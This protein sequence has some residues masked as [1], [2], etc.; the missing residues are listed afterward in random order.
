MEPSVDALAA[1][2]EQRLRS[3]RTP[4]VTSADTRPTVDVDRLAASI[5]E[6]AALSGRFDPIALVSAVD[7]ST[8]VSVLSRL[9]S[10]SVVEVQGAKTQWLLQADRRTDVLKRLVTEQR[11]ETKLAEPLPETDRFGEKL[12]EL[13]RT[14]ASVNV[15]GLSRD[16]LLA[17]AAAIEATSGIDVP[18]P[19]DSAIRQSLA[20]LEFLSDYTVLLEDGFVGRTNEL[21]DLRAYLADPSPGTTGL[22]TGLVLTGLGGAG[23]STLLA[24]FARDCVT[25]K[26][27]TVVVLDFDRPGVE[28]NDTRWLEAEMTRQVSCQYRGTEQALRSSRRDARQ[29]KQV[30]EEQFASFAAQRRDYESSL[31]D[32]V[33]DLARALTGAGA[34][35]RPLLLVLDTFEEVMQRELDARALEWLNEIAERLWPIRLKVIFSG[36]LFDRSRDVLKRHGVTQTIEVEELEPALAEELLLT[37]KVPPG[38]A[39]RLAASDVLPRRPLELKLLARLVTDPGGPPLEELEQDVRSG[40]DAARELFTGLVYRRVLLR[41]KNDTTR[42]LAYPGLVLR[43]VT[44]DLVRKVLAPVLGLPEMDDTQAKA[45]LDGLAGYDWLAYRGANGEVWH[46]KDLRRSILQAMLAQEPEKAT[47]IHEEAIK[48]FSGDTPH[49]RAER[50]YHRLMLM[51]SPEDDSSF[52]LEDLKEAYEHIEA[53]AVDLPPRASALLRFGAGLDLSISDVPLLPPPFLER[54]YSATGSRKVNEREFGNALQLYRDV[55]LAG[56]IMA[57]IDRWEVETLYAT[58]TWND[59]V[60]PPKPALQ[61]LKYAVFPEAV[62]GPGRVSRFHVEAQLRSADGAWSLLND[63]G[64]RTTIERLAIGLVMLNGDDPFS[65]TEREAIRGFLKLVESSTLEAMTSSLEVA[66]LMLNALATPM[67]WQQVTVPLAPL[68]MPID[69]ASLDALEAGSQEQGSP[70]REAILALVSGVRRARTQSVAGRW[71]VRSLLG[72]VNALTNRPG[73]AR[74]RVE[75]AGCDRKHTV[76]LLSTPIPAFRDPCRFALLEAF[77]DAN[78]YRTLAGFVSSIIGLQLDD[79]QPDAFVAAV[80]A[81]PEHAL[82]IYVEATDRCTALGVL[83]AKAR[84]V[85]PD[86]PKLKDVEAA[87]LRWTR[88]VDALFRR[89]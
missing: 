62:M 2:L 3:G 48:Y 29:K 40:G 1:R 42:T 14:G 16:D 86:S 23:K 4:E 34:G 71:T 10:S 33:S 63:R 83:L 58:A 79:L 81:N 17:T 66:L 82:E 22:W 31:R 27:A 11:L 8:R 20:Q 59:P 53:D 89:D 55:H 72:A 78:G 52:E 45:A 44:A 77:T 80:S 25:D 76:K 69:E 56:K 64:A 18:K 35:D 60:P 32:L 67:D 75:P 13:L 54:A 73:G 41:I 19:D 39:K 74:L 38:L 6:A 47:R 24:K 30:F 21:E 26:T 70:D 15:E 9:A 87:Y 85:R 65:A 84:A 5:E 12:R 49:D 28:P 37:Y 88:A 61:P 68:T 50:I 46:R 57:P 36:R 7:P 51:R 43:Y